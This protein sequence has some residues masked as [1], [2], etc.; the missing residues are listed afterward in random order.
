MS[1]CL[2]GLSLLRGVEQISYRPSHRAGTVSKR[3]PP[4]LGSD[5]FTLPPCGWDRHTR[6]IERLAD[7]EQVLLRCPGITNLTDDGRGLELIFCI[8]FW[9]RP[10]G[11]VGL[12]W[13]GLVGVS[14]SR[15]NVS[16]RPVPSRDLSLPLRFSESWS[17][18]V[19]DRK[20]QGEQR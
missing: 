17:W 7:S 15:R 12:L 13:A 19:F 10:A 2:V 3:G 4:H 11:R 16:R 18:P 9:A 20:G 6:V 8:R 1:V 5:L 14:G